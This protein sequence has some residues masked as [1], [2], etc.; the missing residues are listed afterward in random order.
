MLYKIP[1][2]NEYVF[3]NSVLYYKRVSYLD[4]IEK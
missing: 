3:N 2:P 4:Y 1:L